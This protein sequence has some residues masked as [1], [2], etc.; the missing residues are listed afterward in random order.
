MEKVPIDIMNKSALC[1][2]PRSNSLSCLGNN[3]PSPST[4]TGAKPT[5]AQ[6]GKCPCLKNNETSWKIKCSSCKQTWHAMCANLKASNIPEHVIVGLGKTWMCPWCFN[7]P[8]NRPPG[9]PSFK[10]ESALM[11]TAISDIVGERLAEEVSNNII[12]QFQLSVDN[13]LKTRIKDISK[14]IEAQGK[15]FAEGLKQLS[16][17]KNK[18]ISANHSAQPNTERDVLRVFP[19]SSTSNN[20]SVNPTSHINNYTEEFLSTEDAASLRDA[21]EQETYSLVNGR[22]VASFGAEYQYTGSPRGNT[23]TIHTNLQTIIDRINGE[24]LYPDTKINQVV[25]NRYSGKT[26]LPEH[27]DNEPTI[28]PESNIFTIT[29]GKQVPIKFKDQVTGREETL[30]R[31]LDNCGIRGISNNLLRSYLSNRKQFTYVLG[32]KSAIEHVLFGVPQGSVLGPLLFL[33]YINDIINCFTD[34][35]VNLVLYADD[36]NIFIT[37]DSRQNLI[38]KANNVLQLK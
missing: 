3:S 12:P 14:T 36:T 24:T 9:H 34:N 1:T 7:T 32:E 21:L 6:L 8:L 15:E 35:D 4:K 16:D 11:G 22:Q 25:V 5:R 26:H 30:L 20:S 19:P 29:V 23:S 2:R 28:K 37:G 27:S 10:N 33:L 38:E 18:L 17:L 31:K 13:L